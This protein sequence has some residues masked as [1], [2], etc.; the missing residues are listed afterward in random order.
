MHDKLHDELHSI[1][2]KTFLSEWTPLGEIFPKVTKGISNSIYDLEVPYNVSGERKFVDLV[3]YWDCLGPALNIYE[4]ETQ[5]TCLQELLRKLKSRIEFFPK[6]LHAV[7]GF[8]YPD[9]LQLFLV[10]LSTRQNQRIVEKNQLLFRTLV[11]DI[12]F[13]DDILTKQIEPNRY[14]QR[15]FNIIF[16][17]PLKLVQAE[18]SRMILAEDDWRYYRI[19]GFL[20]VEISINDSIE[21]LGYISPAYEDHN[22]FLDEYRKHISK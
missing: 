10:L 20:P 12:I 16:L 2:L 15:N 13:S 7:K 8:S 9:F 3:E 21:V 4:F 11:P 1:M 6:Y 14:R 17:D 5:I 18:D 22:Q 19:S